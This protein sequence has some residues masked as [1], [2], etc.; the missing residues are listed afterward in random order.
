MMRMVGRAL[1]V[2]TAT[3]SS[4]C[5]STT[6]ES[7]KGDP[8]NAGASS[9]APQ[10]PLG[11]LRP[12]FD[13]EKLVVGKT[14]AEPDPHAHH[15]GGGAPMQMPMPMPMP[16]PPAAGADPA[17]MPPVGDGVL[18]CPM[19]PEVTSKDP[20][21]RCPKCGMKLVAPTSAHEGH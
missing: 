20:T 15:H 10:P 5:A 16:M 21:A 13:A 18:A 7:G 19:H 1:L 14:S 11:I 9:P 2:I 8:A 6:I 3:G 12:G 17:A 4:G